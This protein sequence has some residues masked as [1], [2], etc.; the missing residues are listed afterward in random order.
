MD[1]QAI[2]A[3]RQ[4][5][6]ATN[7]ANSVAIK[8][9]DALVKRPRFSAVDFVSRAEKIRLQRLGDSLE[10]RIPK[11]DKFL[12]K[13]VGNERFRNALLRVSS[14]QNKPVK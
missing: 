2:E 10:E 9:A 4:R 6:A 5:H 3:I 11:I 12:S 14:E 13:E 8:G 1:W 7:R